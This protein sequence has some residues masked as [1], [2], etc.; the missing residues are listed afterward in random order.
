MC[1]CCFFLF[2]TKVCSIPS[3]RGRTREIFVA[4]LWSEWKSGE[5]KSKKRGREMERSLE[6]R[7]S[8]PVL[9]FFKQQS[10]EF[11]FTVCYQDSAL[12][13]FIC[14]ISWNVICHRRLQFLNQAWLTAQRLWAKCVIKLTMKCN[15]YTSSD[16]KNKQVSN[17]FPVPQSHSVYTFFVG[18]ST[19]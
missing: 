18:K 6:G 1:L 15:F 11:R 10:L 3:H 12:L 14:V 5:K 13:M 17:K 19:C 4:E 7:E 16:T 8:V 9:S 2:W